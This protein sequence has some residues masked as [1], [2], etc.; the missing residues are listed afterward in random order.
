MKDATIFIS[1]NAI[2]NSTL[3]NLS[4]AIRIDNVKKYSIGNKLIYV[5]Y[6]EFENIET[7]NDE[8]ETILEEK[9]YTRIRAFGREEFTTVVVMTADGTAMYPVK[10]ELFARINC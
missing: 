3:E 4:N 2:A 7:V 8:G 9:E 1:R 10:G 5:E 6:A